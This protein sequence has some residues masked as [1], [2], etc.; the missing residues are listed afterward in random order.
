MRR[1]QKDAPL[2]AR[3]IADWEMRV[4]RQREYIE[5]LKDRGLSTKRAERDL[6]RVEATL[7]Q[8]RNHSEVMQLLVS[9]DSSIRKQEAPSAQQGDS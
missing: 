3:F 2:A 4:L 1:K 9:T 6:Q 5:Q 8:L 7:L